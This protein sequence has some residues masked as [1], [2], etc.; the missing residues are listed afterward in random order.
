MPCGSICVPVCL[1]AP[2]CVCVSVCLCV[3]VCVPAFEDALDRLHLDGSCLWSQPTH[4]DGVQAWVR[5][6]E[7]TAFSAWRLSLYTM[8]LPQR[9]TTVFILTF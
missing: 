5:G 6:L 8:S 1:C 9:S 4:S 3:C 7:Q 2:V